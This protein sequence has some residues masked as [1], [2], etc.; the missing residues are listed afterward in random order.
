MKNFFKNLWNRW[1][2]VARVIGRFQTRVLLTLFYFVIVGPTSM[3]LKLARRDPLKLRRRASGHYWE[4]YEAIG[5][6]L[7][8]ARRQF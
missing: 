5:S 1:K 4:E 2:R 6:E 3:G 8:Q 7:D